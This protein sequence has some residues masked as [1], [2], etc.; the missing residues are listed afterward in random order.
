MSTTSLQGAQAQA[1][2]EGTHLLSYLA[3]STT[4]KSRTEKKEE[5]IS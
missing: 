3:S 5:M 2:R 1:V 4:S